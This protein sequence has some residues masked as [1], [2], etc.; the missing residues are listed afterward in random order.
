VRDAGIVIV[1]SPGIFFL[2][3][4]KCFSRRRARGI[5]VVEQRETEEQSIEYYSEEVMEDQRDIDVCRRSRVWVDRIA[6]DVRRHAE[7]PVL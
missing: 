4:S 5:K 6:R 2:T 3:N 1:D 7:V